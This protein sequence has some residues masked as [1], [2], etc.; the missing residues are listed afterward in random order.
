MHT[1]KW[2]KRDGSEQLVKYHWKTQQG[3]QSLITDDQIAQVL[4][5]YGH[6]HAQLDLYNSIKA[7]NYPKWKLFV[8]FMDPILAAGQTFDP[9][10]ATKIW[11][12]DKFPLQ[13]VGEMV[14]N[15]TVDNFHN[16]NEMAAFSPSMVV[17]GIYYSDDKL[18]QTRLFSY[19]DTQRYRLG[20]NYLMLPVNAPRCPFRNNHFDGAM[21][22]AQRTSEVNYFPSSADAGRNAASYPI[23]KEELDGVPTRVRIFRENNFQQPGDRYR[24]FDDQRKMR[25]QQRLIGSFKDPRIAADVRN[26]LIGYWTQVD[27]SL[28]K[29][30][31][32]MM[33]TINAPTPATPLPP[34]AAPL[35]APIAKTTTDSAPTDPDV[36]LFGLVIVSIL[37]G[38]AFSVIVALGVTIACMRKKKTASEDVSLGGGAS[39]KLLGD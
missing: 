29:A 21:N 2:L 1:Y 3:V 27:A 22:F 20:G 24:L 4:I 36:L 6:S 25:F 10:D 34:F 18:L 33:P 14:L 35:C 32:D 8:Q 26:R 5:N 19:P 37:L 17:P 15:G 13:E 30:I 38:I 28:G 7:G 23:T 31:T 16:E 11:P 12:E 39:Y 9:L